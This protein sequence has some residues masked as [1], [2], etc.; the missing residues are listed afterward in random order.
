MD[1]EFFSSS[2]AP[3]QVGWDWF[4]IQLEDGSEVTLYLL[5]LR[6]G[7]LAPGLP[8]E[9]W[10]TPK[11]RRGPEP[12]DFQAKASGV[13]RS[14]HSGAEYPAGWS[15]HPRGRPGTHPDPH[16]PGGVLCG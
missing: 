13:W 3:G 1:H 6:D 8:R 16:G 7:S 11:E 15:A 14:P 12:A 9:P 2:M 10:W 5:R 4:A